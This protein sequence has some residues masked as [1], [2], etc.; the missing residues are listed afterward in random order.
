MIDDRVERK[1]III[2]RPRVDIGVSGWYT[3]WYGKSHLLISI[4]KISISSDIQFNLFFT[5]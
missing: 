4:L 3:G 2:P 5:Q 1:M